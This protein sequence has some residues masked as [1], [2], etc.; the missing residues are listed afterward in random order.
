MFGGNPWDTSD[1]GAAMQ[2]FKAACGIHD[3][4]KP[5]DIRAKLPT[6]TDCP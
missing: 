3:T 5:H 4:A 1:Q 2:S 6:L